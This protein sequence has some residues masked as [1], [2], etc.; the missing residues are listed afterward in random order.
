MI[1]GDGFSVPLQQEFAAQLFGSWRTPG[2]SNVIKIGCHPE[3]SAESTKPKDPF[4][5]GYYGFFD[6]LSATLEVAQNDLFFLT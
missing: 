4:S 5:N 6:S 1:V 2:D 3:R